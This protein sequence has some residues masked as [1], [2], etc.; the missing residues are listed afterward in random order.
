[1]LSVIMLS[2][3]MLSV[4]LLSDV[5][6]TFLIVILILTLNSLQCTVYLMKL[7]K[8]F[9]FVQFC[10]FQL[11]KNFSK[12]SEIFKIRNFSLIIQKQFKVTPLPVHERFCF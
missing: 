7:N 8:N 2:V 12:I 1:M 11:L 6:L 3:V 9:N 10:N 5:A 4:V